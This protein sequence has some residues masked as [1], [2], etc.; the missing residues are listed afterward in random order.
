[1]GSLEKLERNITQA[2][3]LIEARKS[4]NV[5]GMR[6]F[7]LGL[8]DIKPHIKDDTVYDVE[9]RD[10]WISYK[11]LEELFGAEN[12]GN[13]AN[14]KKQIEK[15][16]QGFIEIPNSAGGF[17]LSHIYEEIEY[18]PQQGLLIRFHDKLKP[19]IL[20][21]VDK[22]YTSY[23]L[24]L[25]FL[26]SSEYSQRIIELLLKQKGF[27]KKG[28][29]EI[30]YEITVEELRRELN[31]PDDLYKGRIDNFRSRVLDLPMQEINKKTDYNVWYDTVKRGRKITGFR[32]WLKIK[33][34]EDK[35]TKSYEDKLEQE[36]GQTRLL[37]SPSA[38]TQ[39]GL[40]ADQQEAYDSLINRG[41][42]PQKA[43]ELA[44]KYELKRIKN[45]LEIAVGQ[46]ETSRN[47]PGLIISLIEQDAAGKMEIEKQEARA[48]IEKRQQE[49]RQAYDDFHGTT[50]VKIGKKEEE[51]EEEKIEKK[52]EELTDI[53]V[54]MICKKGENAGPFLL[55]MKRLGLTIEDVKAGRRK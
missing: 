32:L 54:E 23:K 53:E 13:I 30:Y 47:L 46:K 14:L 7:G 11:E 31:I 15:A 18:F 3:P 33:N 5:T 50:F 21:L 24:K 22:A 25:L 44:K 48:R 37:E 42:S 45:N 27:F 26:L 35:E 55:K 2:N 1:M 19:Y 49:R 38:Q 4:M 12:G 9:F 20:E 29:R 36:A 34:Q 40:T 10:T 6:I 41:V 39:Q 28:K 17:K 51:K 16:F 8:S 43:E 52:P